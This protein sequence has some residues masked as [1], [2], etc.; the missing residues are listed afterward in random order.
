MIFFCFGIARLVHSTLNLRVAVNVTST[1]PQWLSGAAGGS[2]PVQAP[3]GLRG[4]GLSK[5][6]AAASF[7][8][9][10]NTILPIHCDRSLTFVV[11]F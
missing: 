4:G 11:N 7:H 6:D 10:V 1:R 2:E 3:P 8:T 5:Q 9:H